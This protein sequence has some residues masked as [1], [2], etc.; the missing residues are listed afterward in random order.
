M[1]VGL[2]SVVL[3]NRFMSLLVLPFSY[4]HIEVA[5]MPNLMQISFL[6]AIIVNLSVMFP[7]A[8]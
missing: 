8:F 3:P 5:N 2:F 4:D 7:C 1:H 6:E